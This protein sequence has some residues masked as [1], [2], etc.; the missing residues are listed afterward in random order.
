[1]NKRE[2][3]RGMERAEILFK[4]EVIE[5]ENKELKK[6]LEQRAENSKFV[7]DEYELK[8]SQAVQAERKELIKK[9][10]K[11]FRCDKNMAYPE[12]TIFAQD[13]EWQAFKKPIIKEGE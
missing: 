6:K 8:L 1:M 12:G 3:F 5:K 9:I 4:F 2:R 10:E 7:I 11:N 13:S